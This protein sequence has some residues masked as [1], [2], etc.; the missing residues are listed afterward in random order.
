MSIATEIERIQNAKASIKKAIENKGVEVGNG[1]IDTYAN[2]IEEITVS[3]DLSAELTEQNDLLSTQEITIDNIVTALEGKCAG[4][5]G[6]TPKVEGNTLI[7]S[8]G[9]IEGGVL[10]I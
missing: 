7:L 1:K 2:K 4:G 3:E 6:I 5:G 9:T 10:S 8:S